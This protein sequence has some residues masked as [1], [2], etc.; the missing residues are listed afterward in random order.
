MMPV[1][2]HRRAT[3]LG[4]GV[5]VAVRMAGQADARSVADVWLRSRHAAVPAI[6]PPVHSTEAV[7]AWF[8]TVLLSKETWVVEEADEV[9]GLLVLDGNELDQLY[10]EPVWTGHG[11][12]T[13]LVGLAQRRR[14]GLALWTFQANMRARRF[15][16]RHGFVA[17]R[18]TD[19][20]TNEEQAPDVRY[21][22]GDHPEKAVV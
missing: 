2:A 11:V 12:G 22:W 19:G 8:E 18:T 14:P 20:S 17:V 3:V 13:R 4:V 1:L 10:L 16:E 9:I 7:H 21:V 5:T 15:Y 6:P